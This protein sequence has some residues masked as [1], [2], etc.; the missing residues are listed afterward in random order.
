MLLIIDSGATKADWC[1]TANATVAGRMTCR[2]INFSVMSQQEIEKAM[3]PGIEWACRHD[4]QAV[5]LYGAGLIRGSEGEQKASF[6]LKAAFP[7]AR[8]YCESDLLAAARAVCGRS[9]GIAAIIGTGSN[10][11]RYDGKQIVENTRS[12]GF[13]LGDE[14]GGACLGK[15]LLSDF[16]KGMLPDAMSKELESD[17]NL[18]YM[19]IVDR[20]YRQSSPSSFLGSFAPWVLDRCDRYD[21]ARNLVE[22][23]FSDFFDRSLCHYKGY[24]LPIGFVGGLA[25]ACEGIIRGIADNRGMKVGT[26]MKGPMDGLVEYHSHD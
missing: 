17:F 1:L 12:G 13:I 18:D 4:I 9:P 8:I 7:D 11:C 25:Y 20:V 22:R 23:N 15:L 24:G 19:G 3:S 26:I 10:S 6:C 14:G 16:I 2:G 21:Y 5:H